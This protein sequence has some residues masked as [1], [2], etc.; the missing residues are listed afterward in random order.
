MTTLDE[1]LALP[2]VENEQ[3]TVT[4]KRLGE[5][6]VKP[7]THDQFASYQ[8]RT[9][10]IGKDGTVKL[11]SGKL[12]LLIVVGQTVKPDFSNAD[13]LAKAKCNTAQEFIKRKFKA[14]EIAELANKITEIS[15]F[16]VD[17]N[18]KVEEAKN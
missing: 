6:T 7:M 17:F 5:L 3:E 4:I 8:A 15:G 10:S 2:D 12:N 18:D 1:F 14:G 11:D 9:K 13:F 16:D